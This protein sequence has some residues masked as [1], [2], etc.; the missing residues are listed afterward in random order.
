[1][2]HT[3]DDYRGAHKWNGLLPA[4]TVQVDGDRVWDEGFRSFLTK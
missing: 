1:M 2:S 3:L 4:V